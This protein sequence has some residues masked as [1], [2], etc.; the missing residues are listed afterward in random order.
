[1]VTDEGV[2]YHFPEE[3]QEG[4]GI[5]EQ[6]GGRVDWRNL[7]VIFQSGAVQDPGR[8]LHLPWP[9]LYESRVGYCHDRVPE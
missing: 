7:N 2:E 8:N 4:T 1:V 9:G 6:G 3:E 5:A